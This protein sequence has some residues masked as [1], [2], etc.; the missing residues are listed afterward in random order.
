MSQSPPIKAVLFDC[1][2]VVRRWDAQDDPTLER[3]AGLSAA[4]VRRIAFLPELLTPAITGRTSDEAWRRAVAERLAAEFPAADAELAV[5]RWSAPA[6]EVDAAALELVRACRRRV[7]VAL[8]TNATSRLPRDLAALGLDREFDQIVN[9]SAVGACKPDPALFH[10]ALAQI[11]VAAAEALFVDDTPGHVA[12][13]ERLGLRG[14]VFAGSD[15][16]RSA[17]AGLGLI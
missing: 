3:D 17:L 15:G 9:S 8:V 12:A 6:G 14:H 7:P 10:A 13:A 16:L 11:G 1:D 5:A 4:A 2:G